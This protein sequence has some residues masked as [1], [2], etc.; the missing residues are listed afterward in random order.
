MP[1]L[2]AI[3]KRIGSVKNTQKITRAMKLVAAARLRRAQDA[4]VAA[5]PYARGQRMVE[6]LK[7]GQYQPLSVEQQVVLLYAA[8]NGYLDK[9]AVSSIKKYETEFLAFMVSARGGG[10]LDTIKS[11]KDLDKD[12]EAKLRSVLDEFAK[13]FEIALG[14]DAA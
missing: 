1:S 12:G 11:K 10:M 9:Y 4:I 2:K 5:R 8:T 13:D 3:R 6:L 7:Q 14:K